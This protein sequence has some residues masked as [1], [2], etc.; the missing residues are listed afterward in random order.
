MVMLVKVATTL[1]LTALKT[2][3]EWDSAWFFDFFTV[4]SPG[5]YYTG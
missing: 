5:G 1:Q 3:L 2:V 4:N